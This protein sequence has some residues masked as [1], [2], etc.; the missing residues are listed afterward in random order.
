MVDFT[1][2]IA[3]AITALAM[4]LAAFIGAKIIPFL[5]EK[6]FYDFVALMVKAAVT[7][8][9]DGQGK[10]KFDWVFERVE[11]KYGAYFDSEAI[12]NA[13][14]SAYVDMCIALGK[15]PSPSKE[16]EDEEET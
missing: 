9:L 8:F 6:G 3:W 15:E 1:G 13:I 5:R 12:K 16:D 4:L 14:Q 10:K 2:I 11:A 7:Y